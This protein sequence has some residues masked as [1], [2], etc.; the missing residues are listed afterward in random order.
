[1]KVYR[2]ILWIIFLVGLPWGDS[3]IAG[4]KSKP[5]SKTSC[6]ILRGKYT[7]SDQMEYRIG[8]VAGENIATIKSPVSAST[9][10]VITGWMGGLA[11][12]V[13]WPKGFALQPEVLYSQKGCMFAGSGLRYDIDYLEVPVKVMYRL[14][15]AQVKPFAFVAPYGAYAVRLTEN[16][17]MTSDDTFSSQIHPWDY[18]IGAGGGFDVWK[19]QLSFKYSWGF[20]QVL[21]DTFTVRNNVFTISAGF[22]F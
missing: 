11:F 16:G 14:H 15:M 21:H 4:S 9:Q 19:I 10:D 6:T 18:G 22:L 12:Q 8:I 3:V 2:Y 7:T 13:V 20:A 5:H 1:M 17:D